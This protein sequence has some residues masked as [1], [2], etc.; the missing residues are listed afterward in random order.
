[1][2][3]ANGQK[4][5][6]VEVVARQAVGVARVRLIAKMNDETYE[7]TVELPVRP[8]SPRINRG[9]VVSVSVDAPAKLTVPG[10]MLA[11]TD[12]FQIQVA[13][14]AALRLPEGLDY[15]EQYPYGCDPWGDVA[16]GT[17]F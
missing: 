13:P 10:D 11:G 1:M 15:L 6:N 4:Q 2:L 5:L 17:C 9:G 3:E 7:E 12:S 8:A 16:F 14:W